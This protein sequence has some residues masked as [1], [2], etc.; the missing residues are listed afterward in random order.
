VLELARVL[1]QYRFRKTLV[2]AAFSAEEGSHTGSNAY[3]ADA[4]KAARE[5]EA[6]LNNDIVGTDRSGNGRSTTDVLRV[7]G[8]GPEDSPAR[9]VMRYAQE[10]SERYVPSMHLEM[11]FRLDRFSRG[12]DHMSFTDAGYPAVRFTSASEYFANQHS[13]TDTLANASVPYTTQTARINAAVA[14]SLAF[15]PAAPVV[16]W[17]FASGPRKGQRLPMLTRGESGYDAVLEWEPSTAADL[18]GYAVV[19]RSTTSASWEKE[20]WVGK[21]TR[22]RIPDLS[23]DDIVLGVRAVD[24]DGNASLVSAYVEPPYRGVA[25]Q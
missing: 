10:I 21:V 7:F 15:A 19:M 25:A 5:I 23:I 1:S 12:G 16:D 4:N 3:A 2:F 13:A 9:A 11:V 8:A 17:T 20:I 24:K 6:V 18:A 14:A 22:Y